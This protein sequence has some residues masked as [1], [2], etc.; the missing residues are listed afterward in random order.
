MVVSTSLRSS[1]LTQVPIAAREEKLISEAKERGYVTFEEVQALY[2][3][4]D[5]YLDAADAF[6]IRLIDIGIALVS[7]ASVKPVV[8]AIAAEQRHKDV[9]TAR[10]KAYSPLDP[11]NLYLEEIRQLPVL[12]RNQERWL[13]I[14]MEC[15]KLT[16]NNAGLSS[17]GR[18]KSLEV[19]FR[20]LLIRVLEEGRRI[21]QLVFQNGYSRLKVSDELGYLIQEVQMRRQDNQSARVS[22]LPRLMAWC[23]KQAHNRLFDF[24]G[25]LCALPMPVLQSL[26]KH[27]LSRRTFPEKK[28]L[29]HYPLEDLNQ[30]V[31]EIRRRA[32]Q[33]KQTM[34]VHNLRLVASVAGRFRNQGV[35]ILDLYQEG[36]LGLIDAARKFDYR[37]GWKFSTYA[38]WWIRQKVSRAIADQSR[39]IRLPVHMHELLSRIRKAQDALRV[40]LSREPNLNEL[41]ERCRISPQQ[42]KMALKREPRICSLDSSLC[43]P[44]FPLVWVSQ[45]SGFTQKSPCPVRKA[46]EQR[47]VYYVDTLYDASECP[48]CVLNQKAS[49]DLAKEQNVDY[50]M[51][52]HSCSWPGNLDTAAAADLILLRQELENALTRLTKRERSVIMK[53]FGLFDGQVHSLEEI[54]QEFNVTRER[55]RQLEGRA[56]LRLKRQ[57]RIK[58]LCYDF[59]VQ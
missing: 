16:I 12:T 32:E 7:A 30:E 56:L 40:E 51:L 11:V 22:T 53:R 36:N 49:E 57:P 8:E 43:C 38:T 29:A 2:P 59:F 21:R 25:Y 1:D 41:A 27:I 52:M 18:A 19:L 46:A 34:I 55:I 24:C 26:Q 28:T 42:A 48:P 23:P 15:P 3:A 10:T 37:Q 4:S 54:G 31:K 47:Y 5:E 6:L 17:R 20:R 58:S 13:G 44:E 39:L 9:I 45:E 33:A 50:S 14:A 35:P